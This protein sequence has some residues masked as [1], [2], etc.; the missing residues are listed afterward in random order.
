MRPGIVLALEG[1]SGAGKTT[2]AR[3]VAAAL[4]T[5]WSPEAYRRLS[6]RPSLGYR[7]DGELARLELRLLRAEARRYVAA[8]SASRSGRTVVA[9]TGFLGPLTYPWSLVRA[10]RSSP[11]VLPPLVR[12]AAAFAAADRWGL[13]D[14]VVY[15]A[16]PARVRRRRVA[17]D[18]RSHPA[19]F[20]ARHEAIGCIERALYHRR[21][22]LLLGDRFRVVAGD[23]PP[24]TV[25]RR[26]LAELRRPP[27][28][29]PPDV[30]AVLDAFRG[31]R[32]PRSPSSV[33][34]PP[35]PGPGDR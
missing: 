22:A 3:G 33:R 34:R 27:R 12:A 25:V 29:A 18:P 1:P 24:P 16:T 5:T 6:P 9:D 23:G 15:L 26:I 8:R 10:G 32:D 7:S 13:P 17:G 4:G 2:A 35:P 30:G 19:E 20:A 28:A 21:I 31:G 14:L 11:S